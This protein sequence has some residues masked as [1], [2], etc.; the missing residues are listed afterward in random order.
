M[1]LAA[2][3][4][5][6]V[7]QNFHAEAAISDIVETETGEI[8]Y[9]TAKADIATGD[10]FFSLSGGKVSSAMPMCSLDMEFLSGKFCFQAGTILFTTE[11]SMFGIKNFS[12]L[13]TVS[14]ENGGADF[15]SVGNSRLK[16]SF[17][18]GFAN[19][20]NGVFWGFRAV[21]KLPLILATAARINSPAGKFFLGGAVA[22]IRAV[23]ESSE[24]ILSSGFQGGATFAYANSVI[25]GKYSVNFRGGAVFT[26]GNADVRTASGDAEIHL[27]DI[28][29]IAAAGI[30]FRH[31]RKIF[32]WSA[33]AD[34]MFIPFGNSLAEPS[35]DIR[36]LLIK[37]KQK[38]NFNF[39]ANGRY[40]LVVP[41][42]TLTA[43]LPGGIVAG[44]RKSVPIPLDFAGSG[45][46]ALKEGQLSSATR[47]FLLSGLS[48]FVGL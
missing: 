44:I 29:L 8:R 27:D 3:E 11:F 2:M 30:D 19:M 43:K 39:E 12:V 24:Q 1:L 22:E 40:A 20:T 33:G 4:F 9:S 16:L 28:F 31:E 21:P 10:T 38:W 34:F 35:C 48:F 5:P 37:I 47:T 7:A 15:P 26:S 46:A 42:L 17:T 25:F 13:E 23:S 41:S 18:G 14:I 45:E 6:S 36:L 32:L